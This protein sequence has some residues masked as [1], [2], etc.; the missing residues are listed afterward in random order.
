MAAGRRSPDPL[1]KLIEA[2]KQALAAARKGQKGPVVLIGKSMGGRVGCHVALQERVDALV[3]LGYP[4]RG[5]NGSIRDEVLLALKTPILFVQ[6][7]RDALG[8]LDVLEQVRKKMSAPSEL[9]VVEDAN[10]SLQVPKGKLAARGRTQEQLDEEIL[11]WIE[12]F[13]ARA[14]A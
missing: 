8:P 9:R 13:L 6:G 7:S 3:C 11:G 1:P 12:A 2:H 4:L 5:A 14:R 10:H